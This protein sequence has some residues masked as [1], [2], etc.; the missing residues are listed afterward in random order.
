MTEKFLVD[1]NILVY[2]YDRSE[3][4]KQRKALDIL[5][6]LATGDKGAL[7]TQVLSE[8]FWAVTRKITA[9]ISID[10]A[11]KQIELFI[12]SWEILSITPL[13]VIE[14]VRGVKDHQLSLW[15]AQIWAVARMNQIPV[16]LSEDFHTNSIIEGIRFLN[17]LLHEFDIGKPL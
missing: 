11:S 10:D 14:A 5:D 7:S 12:R 13:V 1:T 9:P 8:F 17:P 2:A 16:V 15:D 3:S 6:W 4:E